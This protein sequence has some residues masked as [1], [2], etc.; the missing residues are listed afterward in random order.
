MRRGHIKRQPHADR[1]NDIQVVN[2]SI[3]PR[4]VADGACGL[5]DDY[6]RLRPYAK[7]GPRQNYL[8]A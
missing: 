7:G 3:L 2:L 4:G 8:A 1:P 5:A 6:R